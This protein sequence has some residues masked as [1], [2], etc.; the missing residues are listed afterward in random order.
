VRYE[1]SIVSIM[2]GL[3]EQMRKS[4][5]MDTI[6]IEAGALQKA[7]AYIANSFSSIMI[8]VDHNTYQVAGK[9]L[10]IIRQKK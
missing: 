8:V 6:V 1:A 7:A 5:G 4:I 9:Q 3:D 10:Q 2:G